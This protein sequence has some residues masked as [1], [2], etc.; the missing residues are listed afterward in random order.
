MAC[1]CVLGFWNLFP[2]DDTVIRHRLTKLASI[3]SIEANQSALARLGKREK[4]RSFFTRDVQVH[5]VSDGH[6]TQNLSGQ[7]ELLE[8]IAATQSSLREA[9]VYVREIHVKIEAS[10]ASAEATLL[11]LAD[12]DGEKNSFAQPVKMKFCKEEGEWRICRVESDSIQMGLVG[13]E[14]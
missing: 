5:F 7:D 13:K 14:N 4:L 8:M 2:S 3:A 1:V 10:D 12:L 6:A 9:H 11:L